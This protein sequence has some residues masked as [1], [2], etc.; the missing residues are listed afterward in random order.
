[1]FSI[2]AHRTP[3]PAN[4]AR[5]AAAIAGGILLT[6]ACACWLAGCVAPAFGVGAGV[7]TAAPNPSPD[8][9]YRV[10]WAPIG[11]AVRYRLHENGSL[12]HEG[13]ETFREYVDK[14]PGTYTYVLTVCVLAFDIEACPLRPA[15]PPL[16]VTVAA[17]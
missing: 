17:G 3:G 15:A 11:G 4:R 10:S 14:P 16:T 6:M 8:G 2:A 5:R 7:V 9:S 13:S 12:S 1:M